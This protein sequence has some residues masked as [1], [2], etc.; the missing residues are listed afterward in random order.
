MAPLRTHDLVIAEGTF[1]VLLTPQRRVVAVLDAPHTSLGPMHVALH[2]DRTP[3]L[4]GGVSPLVLERSYAT[5]GLFDSIGNAVSHAASAVSHAAEGAFNTASHAATT[6]ARPA[7]DALKTAASHGA[8]IVAHTTPFLP[9]S[10]RRQ[11]DAASR[12]I[13][14]AHLGDLTAKQFIKGI[15]NAAKAGLE[16]ATKVADTLV[17]ASKLLAKA[18][19]LPALVASHVPVLRDIEKAL[20]PLDAWQDIAHALR[21]GDFRAVQEIAKNQL[22]RTQGALSL[23]PGVGTG[24]SAEISAGLAV[25]QG[26]SPLDVALRTAYGAIPI[27]PGLRQITDSVLESVLTLAHGGSLTEVAIQVARDKVPAGLPREVFDT[28]VQ[29]VVH[30]TPLA[31]AAQGL[32][33]HFVRQYAPLGAGLHLDTALDHAGLHL[34]PGTVARAGRFVQAVNWGDRT[35]IEGRDSQTLAWVSLDD[36]EALT[37][38]AAA[39]IRGAPDVVCL[40]SVEWGNGGAS[41][42]ADYPLVKRLRVPLVASMVKLSGRLVTA[43]GGAPPATVVADVSTFI[44]RGHDGQTLRNTTWVTQIGA[45]GS[46]ASGPQRVVRVEGLT[47]AWQGRSCS[48][49]TATTRRERR[50]SRC[51][52]RRASASRST[53]SIRSRSV[54]GIHWAASSTPVRAH[55]RRGRRRAPRRGAP[56]MNIAGD[57]SA[58]AQ[59]IR[60]KAGALVTAWRRVLGEAPSAHALVLVLSVAELE[61]RMGDAWGPGE[62]NWGGTQKRPLSPAERGILATN[63]ITA[64]AGDEAVRRARALLTP[65][66]N[67]V[68]HRD[69]SP[70][71]GWYFVW[72]WSFPNDVDAAAKFLEVLVIRRPSVRAIL[73]RA[74]PTELAAAMYATRYYE[75]HHAGDAAANIADYA[76]ALER[77]RGPIA[78]A[79]E[80]ALPSPTPSPGASSSSSRGAL[81]LLGLLG[82]VA[83]WRAR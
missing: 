65:G 6:V 71:H 27:P 68:L 64:D 61:T 26:G 69:Y 23:V 9:D 75:G 10:A 54:R 78:Q 60:T 63:A 73:D 81:G 19:N 56:P 31:H 59:R 72:F 18:G 76:A 57:T 30:R 48:S 17:D 25:L 15:G 80:G 11:L 43:S 1:R 51:P 53:V 66:P 8:S 29:L 24:V 47:A 22:S 35:R 62:R 67:E 20:N 4:P 79:L 58:A 77:V 83:A 7:F 5:A 50:S 32:A 39:T 2:I 52:R 14:R 70:R 46:V 33:D 12:V 34:D 37:V 41:V 28:L 40:V 16:G 21:R 55:A 82:L 45:S 38:Y 42:T 3:F 36:C 49:S 74:T 13:L 44:A